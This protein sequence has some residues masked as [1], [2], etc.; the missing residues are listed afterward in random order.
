M[1]ARLGHRSCL[2]LG[3]ADHASRLA[4]QVLANKTKN[5]AASELVRKLTLEG[6]DAVA[7]T[8][9]A[10]VVRAEI[11]ALIAGS[12]SRCEAGRVPPPPQAPP[13][14]PAPPGAPGSKGGWEG[15]PPPGIFDRLDPLLLCTT[16]AV[17]FAVCLCCTPPESNRALQMSNNLI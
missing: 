6:V 16:V 14:P 8:L 12:R 11:D 15:G 2:T 9:T 5:P 13:P 4:L 17:I 10:D 3:P 7:S 1:L